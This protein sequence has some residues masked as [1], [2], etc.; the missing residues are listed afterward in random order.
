MNAQNLKVTTI[1][2]LD[3]KLI[4]E[5]KALWTHAENAN[6]YNSYDWYLTSKATTN[7]KNYIFYVCYQGSKL[8]ALLPMEEYKVFGFPVLG[9][10]NK[11]YIIETGFLLETYDKTLFQVFFGRLLENKNIYLQKIDSKAATILHELFPKA[12][13]H[14]MSVNPIL[15]MTD[16]PLSNASPSTISQIK[17]LLRKNEDHIEYKAYTDNLEKHFDTMLNLQKYTSKHIKSMDIFEHEIHQRYY[18]NLTKFC[19]KNVKIIFLYFDKKPIGYIYN[20]FWNKYV[21]GEQIAFHNDY[22]KISP[23]KLMIYI[24]VEYLK[25]NNFKILDMGGGITPYKMSFTN[26]YRLLYNVYISSNMF[27]MTWWKTITFVRRMK[28]ILLPKK[29]SRDHEFLFDPFVKKR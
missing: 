15:P 12:F 1:H 26:E 19:A 23:G 18:R 8:V 24:L 7:T 27:A 2:T 4:K 28:Q 5:W 13:I 17:R 10:I 25:K 22:R 14:I 9:S 16:D 3:D 6:L 11:S 20:V 29:F 21:L